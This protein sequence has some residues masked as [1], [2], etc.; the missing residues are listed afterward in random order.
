MVAIL[1]KASV[2]AGFSVMGMVCLHRH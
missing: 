2:Y 1:I